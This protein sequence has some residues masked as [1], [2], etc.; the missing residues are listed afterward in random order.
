MQIPGS[1]Y[2]EASFLFSRGQHQVRYVVHFGVNHV[3][4]SYGQRPVPGLVRLC[5]VTSRP[6][7]PRCGSAGL[8]HWLLVKVIMPAFR[9]IVALTI[10]AP[11][12][13]NATFGCVG[14]A[15]CLYVACFCACPAWS[16]LAVCKGGKKRKDVGR[17]WSVC[18][19]MLGNCPR[20]L[21]LVSGNWYLG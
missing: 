15:R 8:A 14:V 2:V 9:C 12:M 21:T 6:F 20:C 3:H 19:A 13:V 4:V 17:L 7:L 10:F 11:S 5:C 18:L 1:A 16:V